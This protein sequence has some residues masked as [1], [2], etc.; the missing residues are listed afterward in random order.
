MKRTTE[1]FF[2]DFSFFRIFAIIYTQWDFGSA[3]GKTFWICLKV[4]K[5]TSKKQ[6]NAAAGYCYDDATKSASKPATGIWRGD[7]QSSTRKF[8]THDKLFQCFQ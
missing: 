7:D 4:Y 6:A 8:S 1:N 2:A 5:P 3:D